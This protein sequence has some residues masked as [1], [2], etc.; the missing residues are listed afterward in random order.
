[1]FGAAWATGIIKT[2]VTEEGLGFGA[3]VVSG[4]LRLGQTQTLDPDFTFGDVLREST[5][6][7][8]GGLVLGGGIKAIA[9]VWNFGAWREDLERHRSRCRRYD[10]AR[11]CTSG[12]RPNAPARASQGRGRSSGNA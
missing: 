5:T 4:L 8:A 9:A 7:G 6:A 1:M 10:R 2:A 3:E 11:R 12:S